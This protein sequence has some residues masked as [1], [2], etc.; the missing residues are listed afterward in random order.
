MFETGRNEYEPSYGKHSSR[1]PRRGIPEDRTGRRGRSFRR[2]GLALAAHVCAHRRIARAGGPDR[3][4]RPHGIR[5]LDRLR[6]VFEDHDL[7]RQ[8][9]TASGKSD[10]FPLR[11]RRRTAERGDRP[12]HDAAARKRAFEGQFRHPQRADRNADRHAEQGRASGHPRA[13]FAGR[14]GRPRAARAHGAGAAR[15]RRSDL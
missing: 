9:R 10:P 4:R 15:T 8:E 3:R 2:K 1:H 14:L 12:R 13:G 11:R 7:E 5:H 6:R